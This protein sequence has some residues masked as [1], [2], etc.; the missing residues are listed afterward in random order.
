MSHEPSVFFHPCGKLVQYI[1]QIFPKPCIRSV[2]IGITRLPMLA[3]EAGDA[4]AYGLRGQSMRWSFSFSDHVLEHLREAMTAKYDPGELEHSAVGILRKY[5]REHGGCL[6]ETLR[7][8]TVYKFSA[9]A[10]ANA[11]YIHR[12]TFLHRLRRIQE[13]TDINF[14]DDKDREWLILSF[15][16][17]GPG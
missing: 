6:L 17:H 3:D 1:D 14:E 5:D 15:F 12:S 8:Y 13:L 2:H 9:S 7:V 11:M 4:L 10:A 16:L